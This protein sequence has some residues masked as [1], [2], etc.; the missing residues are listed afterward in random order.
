MLSCKD[1]TY[2]ASKSLDA[3]LTLRQ[4]WGMRLHLLFCRLCRRYVRNLRFIEQVLRRARGGK[5]ECFSAHGKL[6]EEARERI[7]H[8]L[9]DKNQS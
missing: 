7:Q 5:L 2:L 1:V 6:S 9:Q 8:A 4:R 3:P